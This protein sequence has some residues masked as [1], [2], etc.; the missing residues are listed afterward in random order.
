M[1]FNKRGMIKIRIP[2]ISANNGP[3]VKCSDMKFS[4]S[5]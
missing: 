2:A 1:K 4:G 5:M 3:I